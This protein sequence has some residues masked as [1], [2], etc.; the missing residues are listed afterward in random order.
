MGVAEELE[1]QGYELR[2]D[3]GSHERTQLWV[4]R[5]LKRGLVLEWF[6]LKKVGE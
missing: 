2:V 5:R 6:K 3:L 1:K 4:D